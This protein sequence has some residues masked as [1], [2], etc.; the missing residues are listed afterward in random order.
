MCY[1]IWELFDGDL[2]LTKGHKMRNNQHK[3]KLTCATMRM[4]SDG[5]LESTIHGVIEVDFIEHLRELAE[6]LKEHEMSKENMWVQ[7]PE[8]A[9]PL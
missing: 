1:F 9:R 8:W 6:W 5:S 2:I 3:V 4:A 7:I